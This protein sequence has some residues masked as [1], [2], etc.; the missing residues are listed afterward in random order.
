MTGSALGREP[1][2]LP[3]ADLASAFG[4]QTSPTSAPAG[5]P[6]DR[7]LKLTGLLAPPPQ[8]APQDGVAAG[9]GP[10]TRPAKARPRADVRDS[11]E[12]A[13]QQDGERALVVIAYLPVSLR[14]T[15]R[16][17]ADDRSITYTAIVLDALDDTHD[18]LGVLLG[19][20]QGAPRAGS[21]FSG[22][23]GRSRPRHD[24]PH[25]QVSLRLTR[26]DLS[27]IDKLVAAHNAANRSA[28][29]A[30]ALRAHLQA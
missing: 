19:D 9:A 14:E 7:S 2:R 4:S 23:G 22:R 3:S 1:S 29:I 30:T 13:P 6:P 28:L 20:R 17:A 21:L 27:V 10:R 11:Q 25:V 12:V 24:E 8:T 5:S 15:L 26:S 18:Q 16:K